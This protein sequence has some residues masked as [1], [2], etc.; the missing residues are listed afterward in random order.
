ML[1]LKEFKPVLQTDEVM[2]L[3]SIALYRSD[4]AL[5]PLDDEELEIFNSQFPT[6]LAAPTS[7]T[8]QIQLQRIDA[9]MTAIRAIK[10]ALNGIAFRGLNPQDTELGFQ[11]IRPQFTHDPT[12]V[13]YRV[14]WVEPA[15]VAAAWTPFIGDGVATPYALPREFGIVVTHLT[16]LVTPTP[17]ISEMQT[18]MGRINLVPI[19]LRDMAIG[20]NLNGV[21]VYPIPTMILLPDDNWYMQVMSD[22]GGNLEVQPGGLV[23]GLGRRLNEVVAA[24]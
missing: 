24:W 2:R 21:A 8:R 14:N 5:A 19:N 3:K 18:N 15:V 16:S 6:L 17:L 23:I 13:V 9:Y 10:Q 22:V 1:E 20:D 12:T 7:I 11:P 4:F